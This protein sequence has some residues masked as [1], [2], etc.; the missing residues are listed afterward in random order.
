MYYDHKSLLNIIGV[1]DLGK[2][3]GDN[4]DVHSPPAEDGTT[5]KYGATK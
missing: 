5:V 2:I 4:A 1:L 3:F